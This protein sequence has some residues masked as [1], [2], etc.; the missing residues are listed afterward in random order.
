MPWTSRPR[1][2][3][4]SL[5]T[6]PAKGELGTADALRVHRRNPSAPNRNLQFEVFVMNTAILRDTLC[7]GAAATAATTVA[8]AACGK[9]ENGNPL[10]PINAISHIAWG[11]R[12]A[13]QE[14]PSWKYTAVGLALN[15]AAVTFWAGLFEWLFG[16]SSKKIAD[17]PV[18]AIAKGAAVSAAA[19]VTDYYL[20]PARLTPG[21]EKRLSNCS[22]ACVY[23]A[24]AIS[25][26]LGSL[27][28]R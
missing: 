5:G 19:Y 4:A 20:V 2:K 23:G 6:F 18:T 27:R 13:R 14:R 7:T 22:L 15:A 24:L 25:L 17:D 1:G 28:R 21:F 26:A 10:A 12:A 16:R 11:E 8:V 9:T 3:G